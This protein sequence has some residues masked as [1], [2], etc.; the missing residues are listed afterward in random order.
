MNEKLERQQKRGVWLA[1]V[2]L[3]SALAI[4]WFRPAIDPIQTFELHEQPVVESVEVRVFIVNV[5]DWPLVLHS[6]YQAEPK[7]DGTIEISTKHKNGNEQ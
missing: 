2:L 1:V 4:A 6:N 5:G 3:L 7:S